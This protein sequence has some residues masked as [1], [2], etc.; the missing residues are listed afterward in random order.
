M[1]TTTCEFEYDFTLLLDGVSEITDDIER[2][3]SKS[4]C[5][6]ATLSARSGRLYLTFSRRA[7]SVKDAIVSAVNNVREA[8]I[9]ATVIRVDE[10]S[11][12]T[13][14]E[15]ARRID[16]SRQLVSQYITGQRGP[17]G[18]PSPACNIID[19]QPLWYWCEVAYWLFENNIIK[20]EDLR[21]AQHLSVIN[22]VLEVEHQ[23]RVA[24]ELTKEI[25]DNLCHE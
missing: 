4:G 15:I 25:M 10:C 1:M 2:S 16:R 14:A 11:L 22:S 17:G 19:G 13:Q 8:D 24:P 20:E 21:E 23:R 18:F 7:P 5:D 6:D 12:V 9:G 3:L